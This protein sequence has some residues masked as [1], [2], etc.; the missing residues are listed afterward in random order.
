MKLNFLF[1]CTFL[2][3]LLFSCADN[4]QASAADSTDSARAGDSTRRLAKNYLKDCKSLY[5]DARHSDSIL[6]SQTEIDVPSAKKAI[7]DFT[8]FAYYCHSDT[9]SPV[10]LIKT[11][12]VARAINDLAQAKLVLDKC[13]EDYPSF[14]NRAAALFLLAQLYDE[15]GYLNNE[16]EAKKIYQKIVDEYPKSDWASSAKGAIGFIGKSDQQIMEELKKK[17]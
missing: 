11:A 16:Q 3:S 9:L 4:T 6:L 12:Q 14:K 10:Y 13:I 1:L 15:P 7:K 2:S 5:K 17:K 8:N